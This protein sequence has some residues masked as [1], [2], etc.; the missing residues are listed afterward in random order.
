ML[1]LLGLVGAP[2]IYLHVVCPGYC[3]NSC[4]AKRSPS[5]VSNPLSLSLADDGCI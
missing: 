3:T 1:I 5:T 2:E 4:V